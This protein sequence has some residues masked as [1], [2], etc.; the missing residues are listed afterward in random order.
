MWEYQIGDYMARLD[1]DMP[2]EL[3][4]ATGEAELYFWVKNF[5]KSLIV[6]ANLNSDT[7]EHVLLTLV[8]SLQYDQVWE[9][10]FW[11]QNKR[12]GNGRGQ[13]WI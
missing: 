3:E 4:P 6:L 2:M 8:L 9:T 7:L 12:V 1:A 11:N 13:V 10:G 5:D